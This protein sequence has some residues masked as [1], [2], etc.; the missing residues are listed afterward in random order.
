MS[1]PYHEVT[2]ALGYIEAQPK[3][4]EVELSE[5]YAKKYY[6]D[7]KGSY[8]VTYTPE[9]KAY[10][11]NLTAVADVT[12]RRFGVDRNLLDLGCGEG[13][14]TKAFQDLGWNVSCS[15]YSEFGIACHNKELLPYFKAGDIYASIDYYAGKNQHFGLV[16]LQNVLEHVLNPEDLLQKIKTILSAKSAL[17][18][19]VPNDYS[20]FQLELMKQEYVTNTW[21]SPPEHLSY[22]NNETL[23]KVLE[24]CGYKVA[25]LQAT[26]PIEL[27][28]A[29]PHS[30]YWKKRELGKGA[31]TTRVF[32]ENFLIEK[33]IDIYI[34]YAE[35]AAKLGFGRNL[36]AYA[37]PV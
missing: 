2:H 20:A 29:N 18:V 16:N 19:M 9:E 14:Y 25:S 5:Y 24:H 17:R 34:D 3:P 37:V 12:A 27:F 35:A 28:L 22:F 36:I 26:F 15:D 31:H 23:P 1:K 7:P 33:N 4:S 10:F 8:S 6:Q 32:C 13:Y 21:F 11:H 30:N